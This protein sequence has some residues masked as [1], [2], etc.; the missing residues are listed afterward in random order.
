MRRGGAVDPFGAF[1]AAQV[2]FYHETFGRSGRPSL[3]PEQD[4][5]AKVEQVARE[6]PARLAARRFAAVHVDRQADDDACGRAGG[7]RCLQQRFVF[8]EFAPRDKIGGGGE[9]PAC[10]AKGGADGLAADIKPDQHPAFR[11]RVAKFQSGG[12]D[13]GHHLSLIQFVIPA[14]AGIDHPPL[15]FHPT[16]VDPRVRGGD[17]VLV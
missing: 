3:V 10:V 2:G 14:K 1:G 7:D 17:E 12:C 11:Q 16:V 5:Q 6:G 15:K 13:D 9:A 8:G 4:G